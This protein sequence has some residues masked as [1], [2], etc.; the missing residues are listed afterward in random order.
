MTSH[1]IKPATSP[2][3]GKAPLL[4]LFFWLGRVRV[5]VRVG[6]Y[7]PAFPRSRLLHVRYNPL[8]PGTYLIL[9]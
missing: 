4:N 3:I 9:Y 2:F 8:K 6:Y 1:T 5:R 7:G